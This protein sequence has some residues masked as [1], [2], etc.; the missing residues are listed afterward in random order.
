[1]YRTIYNDKEKLWHGLKPRPLYNPEITIGEALL[2]TM[3]I[4]KSKIAQV[5]YKTIPPDIRHN[6]LTS[7]F[8]CLR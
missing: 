8:V 5:N 2:K 7:F 6:F 1:M 3:Q 4:N